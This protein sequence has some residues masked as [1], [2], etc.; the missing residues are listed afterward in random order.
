MLSIINSKLQILECIR[1]M[2]QK[3]IN[4]QNIIFH[5]NLSDKMNRCNINAIRKRF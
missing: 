4:N 2:F 3:S 1:I 5:E